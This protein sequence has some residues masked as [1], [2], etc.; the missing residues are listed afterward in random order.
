MLKT[1]RSFAFALAA[2]VPLMPERLCAVST[3]THPTLHPRIVIPSL[4]GLNDGWYEG[5]SNG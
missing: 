1:F 4:Q 5:I 3:I 2:L